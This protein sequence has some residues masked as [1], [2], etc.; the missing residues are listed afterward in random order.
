MQW[1]EEN[2]EFLVLGGGRGSPVY[3]CQRASSFCMTV[4][5]RA[6]SAAIAQLGERLTE[7]LKAPGSIPGL[8]IFIDHVVVVSVKGCNRHAC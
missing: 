5:G 3:T 6:G 8:V 7:D 4:V 1:R 2:T